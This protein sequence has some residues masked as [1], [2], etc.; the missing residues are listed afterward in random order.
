MFP[1]ILYQPFTNQLE[2]I[3]V[4]SQHPLIRTPK[5]TK[6]LFELPNVRINERVLQ[7]CL[8]KGN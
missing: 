3:D 4:Y 6:N 8:I 7:E 1:I 2:Q 5:G